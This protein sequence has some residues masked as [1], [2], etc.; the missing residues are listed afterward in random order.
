MN[1]LKGL[2]LHNVDGKYGTVKITQRYGM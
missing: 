1:G 2:I